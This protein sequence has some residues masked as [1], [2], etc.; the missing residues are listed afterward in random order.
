MWQRNIIPE[1]I[2]RGIETRRYDSISLK[3][4]RQQ[5][6]KQ[7]A[8]FERHNSFFTEFITFNNSDQYQ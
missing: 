8:F 5:V 4:N 7:K 6:K 2:I 1:E 3:T